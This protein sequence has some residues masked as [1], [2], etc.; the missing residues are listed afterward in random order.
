MD[1]LSEKVAELSKRRGFFFQSSEAY[2]GVA[3]FQTYGPEGAELKRKL[4][5]SWRENFSRKLGH[6]EIDAPTVMPEPVFEV[7]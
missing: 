7:R 4:E 5:N 3:G 2:G 1:N 6:R